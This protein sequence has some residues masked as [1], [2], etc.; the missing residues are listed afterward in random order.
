MTTVDRVIS[1]SQ[2]YTQLSQ[3]LTLLQL[4]MTQRGNHNLQGVRY[5]LLQEEAKLK[6]LGQLA[7]GWDASSL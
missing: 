4:S 2:P 5:H 7:L 3:Y 1:S 6:L